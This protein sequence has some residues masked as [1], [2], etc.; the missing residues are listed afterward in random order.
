MDRNHEEWMVHARQRLLLPS[1]ALGSG[2]RRSLTRLCTVA[3]GLD[4]PARTRL[5]L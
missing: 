1:C 2:A 3:L 5:P 4:C